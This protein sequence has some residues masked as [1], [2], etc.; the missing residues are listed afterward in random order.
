MEQYL[1]SQTQAVDA[2]ISQYVLPPNTWIQRQTNALTAPQIVLNAQ[3]QLT[4]INA[5]VLSM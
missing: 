4:A 3:V 2:R 1:L 5:M